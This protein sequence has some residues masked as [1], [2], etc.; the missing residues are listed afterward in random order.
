[1]TVPGFVNGSQFFRTSA[2]GHFDFRD[3]LIRPTLGAL[4]N[5]E[6]DYT[7]GVGDDDSS[8]FRVREAV[9]AEVSLWGGH[10]HVLVLRGFSQLVVPINEHVVPFTEL[11]LLGGPNDLRGFRWQEFRDFSSL[12]VSAEYR[13]PLILWVDAALFVDWG[14]VFGKNYQ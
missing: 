7:H 14:G 4:I 6:A 9:S 12:F 1:D 8:Y 13:F 3:N 10:R 2:G 11:S 5:L